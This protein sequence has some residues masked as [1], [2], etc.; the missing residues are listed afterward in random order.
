MCSLIQLDLCLKYPKLPFKPYLAHQLS[1]CFD[2]YLAIH[3]GVDQHVQTA[4]NRDATDWHLQN[5]CPACTYQLEG[6]KELTFKLLFTMDS[7]GSLKHV[8]GHSPALSGDNEDKPT[9]RPSNK[10][11]DTWTCG[12]EYYL[13][14]EMVDALGR[15]LAE[16][17]P[18]DGVGDRKLSAY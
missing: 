18:K 6:E 10:R 11:P 5:C 4:L 17:L 16:M 9:Q 3:R 2:L 7:N 8:C 14:R 15:A 1:L 12:D 13:E